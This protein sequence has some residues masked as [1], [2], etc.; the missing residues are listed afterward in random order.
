M[1]HDIETE[2]PQAYRMANV[3]TVGVNSL[4]VESSLKDDGRARAADDAVR[5]QSFSTDDIRFKPYRKNERCD[6]NRN[7]KHLG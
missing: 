3:V 2:D 1:V 6:K 4:I 7:A 5:I